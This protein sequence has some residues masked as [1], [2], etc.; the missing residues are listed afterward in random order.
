MSEHSGGKVSL[1]ITPLDNKL[2]LDIPF[3][4][5]EFQ[6][7]SLFPQCLC[8]CVYVRLYVCAFVRVSVC[9]LYITV[10]MLL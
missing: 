1:N 2:E 8:V 9:L 10:Y 5:E 3:Y 7:L 6:L 4:F